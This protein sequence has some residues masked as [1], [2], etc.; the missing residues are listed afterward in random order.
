M[1]TTKELSTY[2]LL[3]LLLLSDS[4]MLFSVQ[5]ASSMATTGLVSVLQISNGLI[6]VK[7]QRL[8]GLTKRPFT[9]LRLSC[10]MVKT[11]RRWQNML[12]AELRKSVLPGSSGYLLESSLWGLQKS[13]RIVS[14][15]RRTIQSAL[16]MD[17]RVLENLPFRNEGASHH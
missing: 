15:T 5:D 14:N 3:F 4:P 6:S 16:K 1:E 8:T 7:R 12:V 10:I 11:G 17:K 13:A 2:L 9:S